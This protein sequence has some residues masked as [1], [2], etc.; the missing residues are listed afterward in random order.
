MIILLTT[1]NAHGYILQLRLNIDIFFHF[2][3][4]FSLSFV[5]FLPVKSSE[6]IYRNSTRAEA[7]LKAVALSIFI[8]AIYIYIC[9]AGVFSLLSHIPQNYCTFHPIFSHESKRLLNEKVVSVPPFDLNIYRQQQY[10][11]NNNK[12]KVSAENIG[13]IKSSSSPAMARN[14]VAKKKEHTII[15]EYD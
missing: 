14:N 13:R 2:T 15:I 10:T 4:F 3:I 1:S 9:V 7:T 12:S 11:K 5:H 8:Y 6:Y